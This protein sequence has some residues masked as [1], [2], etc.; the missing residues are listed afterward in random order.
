M[1]PGP[2]SEQT[3]NP[4][5]A[6]PKR[7]FRWLR[8]AVMAAVP[9]LL[10]WP[11]GYLVVRRA[12]GYPGRA[13]SRSLVSSHAIAAL[14]AR[15]RADS[16]E[17]SR[18][19]LSA[20][21][22]NH[23]QPGRA[24]PLL[25]ALLAKDQNNADAWN[26]LCVAYNQ[27]MRYNLAVEDCAHALRIEPA[28]RLARNNLSF[29]VGQMHKTQSI[30]A[31]QEQTAP[32]A[33]DANFYVAE[34]LNFLHIGRYHR[35]IQAWQRALALDARNAPAANDIGIA[36]MFLHRPAQAIVWFQKAISFDPTMQLARNNLAWGRAELKK[37][38]ATSR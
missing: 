36:Y 23:H 16:S 29:A 32:A 22:L 30:L 12:T 35:A 34:G 28:Y 6:A 2:V 21:Y 4:E 33:R 9:L 27:T 24:I 11:V 19:R 5:E 26:N 13:I 10:A 37:A 20:A 38:A 17:T 3:A 8:Y 18:I 25:L 14:E 31:A 7:P 1:Q 15:A